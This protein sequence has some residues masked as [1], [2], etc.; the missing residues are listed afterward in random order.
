MWKKL[1]LLGGLFACLGLPALAAADVIG[2]V[3]VELKGKLQKDI[4]QPDDG[5]R[6][7]RAPIEREPVD[8]WRLLVDGKVDGKDYLLD[9]DNKHDLWLLAEGNVGK[10]VLVKGTWDGDK[11]HVASL[12]GDVEHVKKA[13]KV[14]VKGRLNVIYPPIPEF[15]A[16]PV[17]ARTP[18]DFPPYEFAPIWQI[19]VGDKTYALNFGVAETLMAKA[20]ELAGRTVILTGVLE[21]ET[22]IRVAGLKA[23]EEYLKV[24][25][26][27]AEVKGKL[28]YV[29][30]MWD[31]GEVVQVCDKLPEPFCKCWSVNYGFE[32]DGKVYI[33]DLHGDK[34]LERKARKFLGLTVT[35]SGA[36][37]GDRLKAD[38]LGCDEIIDLDDLPIKALA[39]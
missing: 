6:Y 3:P 32:I 8:F 20:N 39:Q 28:R 37:Q 22:T 4:A 31:S 19:V 15:P 7:T 16:L 26:T 13:V 2:P 29:I 9:L 25:E 30:T 12:Q 5:R 27:T 1:V 17:E 10:T 36:H 34:K 18:R 14:E 24:T 38:W 11:V 35:A 33:L 21:N 23:G